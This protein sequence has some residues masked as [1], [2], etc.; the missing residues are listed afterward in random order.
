VFSRRITIG[1]VAEVVWSTI[2]THG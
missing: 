1:G 2:N